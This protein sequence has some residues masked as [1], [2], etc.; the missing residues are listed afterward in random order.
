M[1]DH[2]AEVS[3]Q[4]CILQAWIGAGVFG[5]VYM[6]K[7]D[8]RTCAIK[9]IG[10]DREGLKNYARIEMQ[11]MRYIGKMPHIIQIWGV[12]ESP[13]AM[14]LLME[15]CDNGNLRS[16]LDA[17]EQEQTFM[18]VTRARSYL[19]QLL[20]ALDFIHG[21]RQVAH[22]DL[23]PENILVTNNFRLLKLG[24]FGASC[25]V[26]TPGFNYTERPTTCLYRPP[27]LCFGAVN[28]DPQ[29]VDLWSLSC[30]LYEMLCARHPFES[31]SEIGML[32]RIFQNLG[33]PTPA[34]WPGV[35]NLPDFQPAFPMWPQ[36]CPHSMLHAD[37]RLDS[38]PADLAL[39]LCATM[40][41]TPKERTPANVLRAVL[42]TE[43]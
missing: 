25:M 22:R 1:Q 23:K 41:V 7:I 21:E 17:H 3:G 16:V 12:I 24:D 5:T 31:T 4:G 26:E 18:D 40:C 39:I 33:T 34:N 14:Y 32:L 29:A 28:Y 20:D 19:S 38:T 2:Q 8:G 9:R 11:Y 13:D 6:G 43:T 30:I 27:E 36:S 37:G 35:E 10:Y 15:L 42:W